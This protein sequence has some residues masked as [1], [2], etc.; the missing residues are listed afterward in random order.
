[1]QKIS[2]PKHSV[3]L[4]R[5]FGAMFYDAILLVTVLFFASLVVV[6]PFKITIEH[7]AYPLFVLYIYMV[8]FVFFGW[9]WTHGGQTLGLKTW[10]TKLISDIHPNVTWKQAFVRYLASL[11]CWLSLGIGFLWCYTN[12]DRL[13]WNDLMSKTRLSRINVQP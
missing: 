7:S 5:R 11:V 13:A 1:M 6:L 10:K 9:F 12:K 2:N 3:G 4:I 8:G